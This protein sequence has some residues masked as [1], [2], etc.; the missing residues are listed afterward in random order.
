MHIFQ[1]LWS[2]WYTF[3]IQLFT[4][5]SPSTTQHSTNLQVKPVKFTTFGAHQYDHV[6]ILIGKINVGFKPFL[7]KYKICSH[8]HIGGHQKL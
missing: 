7:T 3:D 4:S 2:I 6:G 1:I 5:K 8:G